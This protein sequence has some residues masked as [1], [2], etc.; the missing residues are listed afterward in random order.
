MINEG[1]GY[2]KGRV[3]GL[4]ETLCNATGDAVPGRRR[5][6]AEPRGRTKGH[7]TR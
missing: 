1:N 3:I 7:V 4:P 2:R 6:T 5:P